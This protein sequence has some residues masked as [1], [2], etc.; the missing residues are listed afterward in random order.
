MKR[1]L[2]EEV[3]RYLLGEAPP[4]ELEQ[5][6]ASMRMDPALRAEVDRLRP[7]VSR[8]ET[9]PE[10]VWDPPEVP[11]LDTGAIFSSVVDIPEVSTPE[12]APKVRSGSLPGF[13]KVAWPKLA[14]GAFSVVFLL[15][16]GV[17]IGL[18]FAG[19]GSEQLGGPVQTVE[20]KA[21]GDEVPADASGEVLVA[22]SGSGS[23]DQMKLDVSGLPQSADREYYEV[24]LLGDKG[25]VVALGS[26]RVPSDGTSTVEVP[27]PVSPDRY[28]YF[29]VSIQAENGDPQHSG[30]SVLR[31]LTSS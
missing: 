15:A 31:G 22:S 23:G 1:D 14:V 28:R 16:L 13:F 20:L 17:G 27:L 5:F 12:A 9:L 8:L 25:E 26:F 11:Q 2:R 29:D 10:D 18:Q 21:Y 3:V 4:E 24:W 30:R 19:S 7:A 6:E